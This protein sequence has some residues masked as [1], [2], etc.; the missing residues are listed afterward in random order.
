MEPNRTFAVASDE[1]LVDLISHSRTRLVVI[2]PALTQ[3][4]ADA[5]SVA[6]FSGRWAQNPPK[7]FARW[8][9]EPTPEKIKIELQCLAKR[10]F[11]SAIAFEAP[12]VRILYKNVAPENV[13][14]ISFLETLKRIM[15]A[16]RVPREVIDSLFESGR[17]APETGSFV[18]R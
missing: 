3:P 8:G 16:K 1:A 14:D 2:A 17:A 4:V 18:G 6:E 7:H 10:I 13:R 12:V 9:I 15:V 11:E 5:L